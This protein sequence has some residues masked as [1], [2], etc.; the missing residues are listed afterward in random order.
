[1][2][3]DRSPKDVLE[4]ATRDGVKLVDLKFTDWPGQWQHVTFPLHEFDES[5]FEEGLG[6]DGSS[7]RGWQAIDASDMLMVPDPK[8]AFL[9]PFC[10]HPTLSM[11]C[12]IVDPITRESYTRDPRFIAKKAANHVKLTGIAETAYFGPEAEFFIFDDVRFQTSENAG[13]YYVDSV[14]GQWNSGREEGPNLGYK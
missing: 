5:V 8:T 12:D 9:D 6:F 3:Q 1:M 7:I 14:E 2:H 4:Q 10:D 11:I 13:F